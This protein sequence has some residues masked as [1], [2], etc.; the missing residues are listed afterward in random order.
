[1]SIWSAPLIMSNDL[2][3][4]APEFQRIL[5]NR[6]VIAIDQD[7]LG[8][9]GRLMANMSEVNMAGSTKTSALGVTLPKAQ[10]SFSARDS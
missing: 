10:R 4:I 1:M 6:D 3:T 5:L 9:M 7:P 2:R 8:R